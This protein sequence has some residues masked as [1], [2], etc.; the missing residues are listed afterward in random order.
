MSTDIDQGVDNPLTQD[1]A[2]QPIEINRENGGA[3]D[4]PFAAQRTN[5]NNPFGDKQDGVPELGSS[6]PIQS[7]SPKQDR[8]MSKEWDA[9]KVPP[10]RFQKREGS[11]YATQGSRD[12]HVERNQQT[13][14]FEKLKEKKWLK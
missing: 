9:S 10:S 3:S 1:T 13:A 6:P 8:R 12:G 14:Y 11:I 5:D 7:G 2:V 4:D